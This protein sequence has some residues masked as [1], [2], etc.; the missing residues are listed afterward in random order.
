MV[1]QFGGFVMGKA[2]SHL[3]LVG[4]IWCWRLT[5]PVSLRNFG[6]RRKFRKSLKTGFLKKARVKASMLTY[7][8]KS[9]WENSG[10]GKFSDKFDEALLDL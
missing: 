7:K 3:V 8:T 9:F 5:V 4:S 10:V 1:V 2:S 6:D